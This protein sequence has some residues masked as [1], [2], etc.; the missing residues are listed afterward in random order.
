MGPKRQQEGSQEALSPAEGAKRF[1][2]TATEH[3]RNGRAITCF[4]NGNCYYCDAQ[5]NV[6]VQ[7]ARTLDASCKGR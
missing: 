5:H 2:N 6:S 4:D 1:A 7:T 3:V